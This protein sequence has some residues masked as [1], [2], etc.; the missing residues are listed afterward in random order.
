MTIAIAVSDDVS[1]TSQVGCFQITLDGD[2]GFYLLYLAGNE[3]DDDWNRL[4]EEIP[5]F[6]A[7]QLVDARGVDVED[8]HAVLEYYTTAAHRLRSV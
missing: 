5:G 3:N 8:H 4:L 7:A 2:G 6:A 1:M